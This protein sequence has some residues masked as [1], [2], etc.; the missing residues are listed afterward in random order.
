MVQYK[1]PHRDLLVIVS[2]KNKLLSFSLSM[3]IALVWFL[4][5]LFCKILNFVP[6][7]QL[8]VSRIL[9]EEHGLIITKTIGVFELLMVVWIL[10]GI[11]SRFCTYSQILIITVMN[12]IEII[13][14]PDLL[15]YGRG[16]IF[17]AILLIGVIY[18]NEFFLKSNKNKTIFSKD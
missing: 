3:G 7:H 17:P 18:L 12:V 13:I 14:A 10:S 1:L 6:R 8:I 11:K 2:M 15:L 9:G 4:N 5:G 16:N